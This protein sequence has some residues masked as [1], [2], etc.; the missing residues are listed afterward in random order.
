VD[1]PVAQVATELLG[2][3]RRTAQD[4]RTIQL[5]QR[6]RAW[7]ACDDTRERTLSDV[8]DYVAAREG[9]LL[10][11]LEGLHRAVVRRD[12]AAAREVGAQAQDLLARL[13][14]EEEVD[15]LLEGDA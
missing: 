1:G 3:I 12:A 9:E 14:A 6:S 4:R 5:L 11:S 15:R 10:A 2:A 13:E 7:D 8:L